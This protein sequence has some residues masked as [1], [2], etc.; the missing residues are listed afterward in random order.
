MDIYCTVY[1]YVLALHS[2]QR[3]LSYRTVNVCYGNENRSAYEH[4][5]KQFIMKVFASQ[6][7]RRGNLK[8]ANSY[9]IA[10]PYFPFLFMSCLIN[11]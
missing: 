5:G 6:Q 4:M 2:S 7:M 11:G 8:L 10:F 1:R 9:N 3:P